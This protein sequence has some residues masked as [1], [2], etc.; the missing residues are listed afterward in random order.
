MIKLLKT[1]ASH[2]A[3]DTKIIMLFGTLCWTV[4]HLFEEFKLTYE[5]SGLIIYSIG[6]CW[7]ILVER[8]NDLIEILFS[9]IG[10]SVWV[11]ILWSH[12]FTDASILL[13]LQP[14]TYSIISGW[15]LFRVGNIFKVRNELRDTHGI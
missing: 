13:L 5:L 15:I 10:V 3:S 4:L 1:L 11:Y 2:Y 9:I 14:I 12:I 8:R 7:S 6:L